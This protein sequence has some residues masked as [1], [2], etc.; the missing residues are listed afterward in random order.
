MAEVHIVDIDGEQWDIKD[1]PLTQRV[2][3]LAERVHIVEE[4]M[5]SPNK[6]RKWSDGIL[7]Q[8]FSITR[9][10]TTSGEFSITFPIEFDDIPFEFSTFIKSVYGATPNGI[11]IPS[12]GGSLTKSGMTLMLLS[13]ATYTN[14]NTTVFI[15]VKG[16]KAN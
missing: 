13:T 1:L 16:I 12:N 7:E 11:V 2:N 6:Y 5:Q 9:R 8:W 3:A 10:L 4:D 15:H 14:L